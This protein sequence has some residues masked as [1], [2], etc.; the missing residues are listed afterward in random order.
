[1]VNYMSKEVVDV[2]I[3]LN[4]AFCVFKRDLHRHLA[5]CGFDDVGPSFG[6]IFRLLDREP[7]NLQ[8]VSVALGITAQ[9]ALKIVNDMVEKN[10]VERR[11][12]PDDGRVKWLELTDRAKDAMAQAKRF[13]HQYERGLARR[14]GKA[15]VSALRAVLE[16]I[17]AGAQAEGDANIRPF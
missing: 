7:H 4:V 5:G 9:G 17:Y 8:G 1:M 2:G 13:H 12:D 16:D 10:Y 15:E 3:L 14:L 6:Y 11:D